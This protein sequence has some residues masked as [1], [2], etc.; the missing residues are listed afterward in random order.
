MQQTLLWRQWYAPPKSLRVLSRKGM[1]SPILQGIMKE[2]STDQAQ[3]R[4][5]VKYIPDNEKTINLH[6][7]TIRVDGEVQW[8]SNM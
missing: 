7:Y 3:P 4:H 6:F 8:I 1:V 5:Q 2:P